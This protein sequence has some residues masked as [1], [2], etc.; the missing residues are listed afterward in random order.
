MRRKTVSVNVGI[1]DI[2]SNHSIKTQSMTTAS[3]LDTNA[4]VE[5]AI[6]IRQNSLI[7]RKLRSTGNFLN[8]GKFSY[9]SISNRKFSLYFYQQ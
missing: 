9:N 2:G 7:V 8:L 1:V 4:S 6:R 3:T 5:E